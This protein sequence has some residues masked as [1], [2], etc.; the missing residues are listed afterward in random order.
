[1][2]F[3]NYH[4][5]RDVLTGLYNRR[6]SKKQLTLEFDRLAGAGYRLFVI[7]ADIDQFKTINDR[8]GQIHAKQLE[9]YMDIMDVTDEDVFCDKTRL[10]QVLLNLLSNAIKFTPPGGKPAQTL[11][12]R[13][14][15]QFLQGF[16][17]LCADGMERPLLPVP[18]NLGPMRG[19]PVRLLLQKPVNFPP[20]HSNGCT[21]VQAAVRGNPQRQT[22]PA[23]VR[24]LLHKTANVYRNPISNALL[25]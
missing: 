11:I 12:N 6:Q 7:L 1:M 22:L 16:Q 2:D 9:L 18:E 14:P 3:Q 19:N 13:L 4:I 8:F 21:D 20:G 24:N 23:G 17:L 25:Q 15:G 5:S 10:N